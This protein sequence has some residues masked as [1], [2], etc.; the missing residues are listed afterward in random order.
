[1]RYY[2]YELLKALDD[3]NISVPTTSKLPENALKKRLK[4]GIDASQAVLGEHTNP[5]VDISSL[6]E[7]PAAQKV[8]DKTRIMNLDEQV[9][10]SDGDPSLKKSSFIFVRGVVFGAASTFDDGNRT[11][12]IHTRSDEGSESSIFIRVRNITFLRDR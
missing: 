4:Q 9:L 7:W 8:A 1:M 11:M 6:S 2:V 5:T 10:A 12:S 3:M